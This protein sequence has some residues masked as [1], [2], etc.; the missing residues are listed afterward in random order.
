MVAGD[1]AA[2]QVGARAIERAVQKNGGTLAGS[3]TH[4]PVQAG[5]RRDRP[6]I[7]QAAMSGNVDAVF[8]TANQGAVLPHLTDKLAMRHLGGGCR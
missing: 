6:N 1:D 7:A 5:H 2:G 4:P 3:V 8:R